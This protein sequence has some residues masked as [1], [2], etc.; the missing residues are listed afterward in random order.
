MDP[1]E[2]CTLW[3]QIGTHDKNY[4]EVNANHV[5]HLQEVGVITMLLL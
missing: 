4:L 5:F 2:E 1:M 3:F